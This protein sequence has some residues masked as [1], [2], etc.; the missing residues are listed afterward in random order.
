MIRNRRDLANALSKN[1]KV[2]SGNISK[3]LTRIINLWV[4]YGS[5]E[6]V[7]NIYIGRF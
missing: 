5:V 1:G 4:S 2:E 3:A 7:G 6:K